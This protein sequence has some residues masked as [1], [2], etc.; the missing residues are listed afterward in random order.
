MSKITDRERKYF[1]KYLEE[2]FG[3]EG[4]FHKMAH[5]VTKAWESLRELSPKINNLSLK[6]Q[7]EVAV[8]TSVVAIETKRHHIEE[9]KPLTKPD[10]DKTFIHSI[11]WGYK[12][13]KIVDVEYL[14]PAKIETND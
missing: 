3:S 7:Y 13:P 10:P 14:V 5:M 1:T 12:P 8:A 11:D 6:N 4:N 9:N 2:G